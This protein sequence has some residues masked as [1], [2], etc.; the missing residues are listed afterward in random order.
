[1]SPLQC[2]SR[3]A[4]KIETGFC[5]FGSNMSLI[6][7]KTYFCLLYFCFL[8]KIYN[9]ILAGIQQLLFKD[10]GQE[11]CLLCVGAFL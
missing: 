5:L 2:D 10:C 6:N 9:N 3:P 7:I 8:D 1:M 11:L 4:P